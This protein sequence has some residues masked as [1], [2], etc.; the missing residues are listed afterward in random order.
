AAREVVA[1]HGGVKAL[2][3]AMFEDEPEL[4]KRASDVARRITEHDAE[5]L[6]QYADELAGLLAE[7]PVEESRTRWHLGL[8]VA[9][10]AHTR[11]Q[12]LRAARL[13]QLLIEEES[14]VVRC[15]AVEGIGL[16]AV[17][18]PSLRGVAEEMITRSRR[19]GTCAMKVRAR[20][21]RRRLEKASGK[22]R[23]VA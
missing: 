5:P 23:P 18:E 9:R 12:R 19:E 21:A 10:V 15:S 8:V 20:H 2:V 17:G 16:L 13:M 6:E 7:V 1:S 11:E 3:T 14:N 4:R 22:R